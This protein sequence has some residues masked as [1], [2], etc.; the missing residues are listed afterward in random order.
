MS[1]LGSDF[2]A[3]LPLL[4]EGGEMISSLLVPLL[5]EGGETM[6]SEL[7]V[8]IE[9][10]SVGSLSALEDGERTEAEEAAAGAG[11]ATAGAV[12]AWVATVECDDGVGGVLLLAA[13][14]VGVDGLEP[15]L[16]LP[17]LTEGEGEGVTK[18]AEGELRAL[19]LAD[20]DADVDAE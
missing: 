13:R 5:V 4:V 11:R 14:C 7:L 8:E 3:V 2:E 12:A 15:P 6:S 16:L 10:R 1:G 19:E 18:T 9:G 20:D 17:L